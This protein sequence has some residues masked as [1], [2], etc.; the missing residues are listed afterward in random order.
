MQ[1]F[2]Q[3]NIKTTNFTATDEVRA[4][5][6]KRLTSLEKFLP[7]EETDLSCD[8]ELER[9]TAHQTGRI[10][11][12]EFNLRIGGKLL[13]AEATE[14][15]MEDAIDQ[16]KGDLKRELRRFSDKRQSLMR[17]GAQRVKDMM[18]FGR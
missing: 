16:A 11:R 13:R 7:E 5:L 2:P 17:R 9:E 12:A 18:R 4:I 6:E 3:I 14:E 15:R 8:V 1:T 10:Y